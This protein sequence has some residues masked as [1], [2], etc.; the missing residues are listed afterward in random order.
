MEA[1]PI[2]E[3]WINPPTDLKLLLQMM[4]AS[5]ANIP[6]RDTKPEQFIYGFG[7]NCLSYWYPAICNHVPTP[8]TFYVHVSDF[9]MICP[10][11]HDS[12]DFSVIESILKPALERIGYPA[13]LR[14][15]L[16]SGK[17]SWDHCCKL[18]FSE[19]I[20][21]RLRALQYDSACKNLPFNTVVV[22]ELL[23]TKPLFRC[24][25]YSNMPVV[26]ERRYFVQNGEILYD[27]PYW[28]E[29]ALEL[30]SPDMKNWRQHMPFLNSKIDGADL[31]AAKVAIAIQ[32]R[33]E[34]IPW[35]VDVLDVDGKPYVIDMA[36]ACQ[37]YGWDETLVG[38]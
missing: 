4:K 21:S 2:S 13:F 37:S 29:E 25:A 8:K 27:I 28:P 36:V 30:G 12:M 18:E 31:L 34:S 5:I 23:K 11:L 14:T 9:G 24:T 32:G 7:Q 33:L 10:E 19:D 17:H 22:R 15:G 38:N 16:T 20:Q 26:R 35:S 6:D 1:N 3:E